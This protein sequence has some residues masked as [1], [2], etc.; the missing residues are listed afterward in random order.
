MEEKRTRGKNNGWSSARGINK[1]SKKESS[2]VMTE[3]SRVLLLM[4]GD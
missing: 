2:K 1:F 4:W 3:Y